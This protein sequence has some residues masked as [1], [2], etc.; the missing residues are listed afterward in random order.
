MPTHNRLRNPFVCNAADGCWSRDPGP[1]RQ[2][3]KDA[4]VSQGAIGDNKILGPLL[5][6]VRQQQDE[7]DR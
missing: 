6:Q 3:V 4:R 2:F 1:A 5:G 7:R